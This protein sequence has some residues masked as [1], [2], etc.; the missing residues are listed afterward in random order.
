MKGQPM[1]NNAIPKNGFTSRK[2]SNPLTTLLN[3]RNGGSDDSNL[4]ELFATLSKEAGRE[5][6]YDE[7]VSR[8]SGTISKTFSLNQLPPQ[9]AEADRLQKDGCRLIHEGKHK[10]AEA[11]FRNAIKLDP[12]C[13]D[14]HGNLGVSFAQQRK[15]PE[16][17]AA[18]L[19]SIRFAPTNVTMYVN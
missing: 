12:T 16:A 18:F 7:F 13:A 1:S 15:L 2:T 10:D 4:F 3:I 14:A 8:S 19:L 11:L 17:E 6:L 5:E 9:S